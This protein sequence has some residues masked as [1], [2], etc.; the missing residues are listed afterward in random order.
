M[1]AVT[2]VGGPERGEVVEQRGAAPALPQGETGQLCNTSFEALG[3]MT[4]LTVAEAAMYL[5]CPSVKA[6]R[7][8]ADRARLPKCRAGRKVL[9]FRKDLDAAVQPEHLKARAH[10]RTA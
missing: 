10:R 4:Y 6:F 9:F 7:K 5:R 8:F 1:S 2:R 3:R